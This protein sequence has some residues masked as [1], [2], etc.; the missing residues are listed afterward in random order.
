MRRR[1]LTQTNTRSIWTLSPNATLNV[2]D[3]LTLAFRPHLPTRPLYRTTPPP[4][5]SGYSCAA[6]SPAG[7][8]DVRDSGES[9]LRRPEGGVRTRWISRPPAPGAW[10]STTSGSEATAAADGGGALLRWPHGTP[11][12]SRSWPML[13][14][15]PTI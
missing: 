10:A 14:P 6:L 7:E 3:A 5:S 4:L 1:H 8:H 15:L 12:F 9:L 13:L 2:G 11:I